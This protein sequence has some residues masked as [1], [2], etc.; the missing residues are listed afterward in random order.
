MT[1]NELKYIVE[2]LLMSSE[3]PLTLDQLMNAFED[4]QRPEQKEIK[5]ILQELAL[6]YQ[7]RAIELVELAGGYCIQTKAQY[8]R[9]ISRL[10]AEKPTKYSQALLETLAIIAYKQPVTRAE[11]EAIRGVSI[12]TSIL[13]TLRE[14]EWIKTAGHRD[15]PGKPAVY[16]TTKQFLNYFNLTSIE[17]LPP[18][19]DN[20]TLKNNRQSSL[21]EYSE[22]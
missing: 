12:S 15:V 10:Q 4:W 21:E 18:L 2:A 9:W 8:G 16:V 7:E 19:K 6:D 3:K 14:R 22:L 20:A 13:K 17:Q 1:N 5:K 11:I